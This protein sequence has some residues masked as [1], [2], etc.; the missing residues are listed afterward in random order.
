MKTEYIYFPCLLLVKGICC[1]LHQVG[2]Q[3]FAGACHSSGPSYS[4][5]YLILLVNFLWQI[6]SLNFKLI[7][8]IDLQRQHLNLCLIKD[9]VDILIYIAGN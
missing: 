8:C 9:F 4:H 5:F 6:H 1:E 3:L 7:D 2:I